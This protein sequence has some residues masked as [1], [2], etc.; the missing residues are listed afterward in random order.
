MFLQLL[1]YNI[2]TKKDRLNPFKLSKVSTHKDDTN[3][4]LKTTDVLKLH[5][6]ILCL[7]TCLLLE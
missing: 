7:M 4:I 6:K 2:K 5:I 1:K 3:F